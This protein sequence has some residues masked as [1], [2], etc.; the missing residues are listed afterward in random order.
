MALSRVRGSIVRARQRP[1]L[2]ERLAAV[3]RKVDGLPKLGDVAV[4]L[5]RA[6]GSLRHTHTT[7]HLDPESRFAAGSVSKLFT[8]AIIFRL[9]DAGRLSYDTLVA[10]R[11]AA[12][13]LDGLHVIR[14]EDYG[15]E[16]TVRHLIDHT[17]G[18]A[19]WEDTRDPGGRSVIEQIVDWD[20]VVSVDE[21]MEIAAR[22][23]A[24]F[25]PG[26]GNRAHYSDLNAEL[27]SQVAQHTTGRTFQ[28]LANRY[29]ITPLGL[30]H[31]TFVVPGRHDY[32]EVRTP[33]HPV[34]SSRYL[35]SSPASGGVVS[36]ANDLMTFIRAFHTG[37]IFD[38]AHIQDPQLRRIQ[39]RPLRYGSGMMA[40]SLPK[41]LSPLVPAPLILG[42]TGVHGAFAFYCPSR[43]AFIAGS[44]TS[45]VTSP[46]DLIYRYLDAL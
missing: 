45:I 25:P 33:K 19:S 36:T 46:F 17:S 37:Q 11:V 22:V 13:S 26:H 20:R 3:D 7:G 39:H 32:A 9:I 8:H 40:M 10:S 16:L 23:G 15:A 29:I 1:P 31:T 5:E 30:E 24:K 41:A 4:V 27:L 35:S 38:H 6:D 2:E 14:G 21:Q 12:H 42:H 44:I 18:L 43:S 34:W 28:E